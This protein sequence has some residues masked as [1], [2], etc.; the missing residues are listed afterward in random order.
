MN[1]ETRRLIERAR[2]REARQRLRRANPAYE[3]AMAWLGFTG[4]LRHN[5]IRP[6]RVEV[7]IEDLLAAAELE[8]RVMEILPATLLVLGDFIDWSPERLPPELQCA[9]EKLKATPTAAA[10]EEHATNQ[11]LQWRNT[12]ALRQA[13]ARLAPRKRPRQR[14]ELSTEVGDFIRS[15]RIER[16]FTQAHL[17]QQFGVSLHALRDLEQG[18]LRPS[19]GRVLEILT[20]LNLHLTLDHVKSE[21][22]DL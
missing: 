15:A 19:L 21:G 9:M 14:R 20:T 12:P 11:Y 2:K 6:R 8:P 18:S 3:R 1:G 13:A 16:G 10:P 4:L 5:R 7:S 17:S 22:S